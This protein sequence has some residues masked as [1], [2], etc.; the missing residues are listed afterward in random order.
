M[1]KPAIVL[2][3][4]GSLLYEGNALSQTALQEKASAVARAS[5]RS[6]APLA[7]LVGGGTKARQRANDARSRG[8]SEFEADEA[9][10]AATRE[11]AR[12]FARAL[13]E[14]GV[15]AVYC[16]DFHKAA[17]LLQRG[18]VPVMGGQL[19]GLTTDA[20]A[21]LLAELARAERVVN[22]TNVSG[23]YNK[24]PKLKDARKFPR[25]SHEKLVA[26]AAAQDAREPGQHFVF[27]LLACKLA[28]RSKI[29]VDFV[30]GR[31]ARNIE[32]ALEGRKHGGTT[33]G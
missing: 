24:D 1:K 9:A 8:A 28:A 17:E 12:A 13:F 23:V 10:I 11:N 29:R 21:V 33:V 26:L 22:A 4:G 5:R 2:S 30:D 32:F 7:V 25:L 19:P 20:C 3:L 27:D 6:A 16:E 15:H 14:R 31:D 18:F